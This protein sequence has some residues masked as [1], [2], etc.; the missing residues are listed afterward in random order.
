MMGLEIN[1]GTIIVSGGARLSISGGFTSAIVP[2]DVLMQADSPTNFIPM[3]ETSGTQLADVNTAS[4]FNLSGWSADAVANAAGDANYYE[5]TT[6][7]RPSWSPDTVGDNIMATG[8]TVTNT[9]SLEMW[10]YPTTLQ[11]AYIMADNNESSQANFA[12]FQ[13]AAGAVEWRITGGATLSTATGVM[14]LNQWNHVVAVQNSVG[15]VRQIYV[16]GVVAA[17]DAAIPT[18]TGAANVRITYLGSNR[19]GTFFLGRMHY[20]GMYIGQVLSGAQIAE[21]IVSHAA[22]V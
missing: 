9:F 10:V 11:N 14:N 16:N 21:R 18:F 2:L 4:F 15:P 8:G 12:M 13:T 20:W 22:L 3:T 5:K 7:T 17:S 19:S 6:N 1:S